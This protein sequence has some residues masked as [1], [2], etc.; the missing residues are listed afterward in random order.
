MNIKVSKIEYKDVAFSPDPFGL[1][2][3]DEIENRRLAR[4]TM[5]RAARSVAKLYGNACALM[6]I[7]AAKREITHL[8]CE[9]KRL[10]QRSG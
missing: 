2:T 8:L 4:E 6:A 1:L 3:D 10:T 7:Q 5:V 9:E